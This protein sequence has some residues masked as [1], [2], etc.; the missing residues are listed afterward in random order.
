MGQLEVTYESQGQPVP[1]RLHTVD[2]QAAPGVLLCPGRLREIEGLGF[3]AEGLASAGVVVLATT[4]RGMDMRSD[5][6]DCIDGLSYLSRQPGVDPTRL[7]IAGHSRGAMA[8]LRV[9][10]QDERVRSVVA[11]QPVADLTN[12]VKAMRLLSPLR[13]R[14]L[15]Q[16]MGQTDADVERSYVSLSAIHQAARIKQPVLL[17]AGSQDL[18][19]PVDEAMAL[20]DAISAGG[21][22]RTDLQVVDGMG[23]FF[24]R[25]YGGYMFE[26]I[27]T[28][29]VDW[30]I[31]TL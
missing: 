23:H 9:A 29:T 18:H 22:H 2:S 5:D 14:A 31:S 13:Y 4:Y 12:Y 25:M 15:A 7:G 8:A 16:G 21:N 20:R 24:E 6:Q 11:L 26:S 10:A 27:A 1:G 17:V 3:L 28:L 30:F 19:A